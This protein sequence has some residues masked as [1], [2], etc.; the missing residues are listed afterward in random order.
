MEP[1]RELGDQLYREE[2]LA[3]RAMT[4]E[5]RMLAGAELFEFAC[6]I[7]AAGIRNQYPGASEDE[8]ARRLA[9]RLQL[10]SRLERC[11]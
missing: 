10:Q 5:Q 3:A 7:A 4:P 2:V 9:A 11:G 8:V 1:T 6:K